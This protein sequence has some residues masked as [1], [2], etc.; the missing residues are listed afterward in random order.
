[1]NFTFVCPCCE[2]DDCREFWECRERQLNTKSNCLKYF[3]EIQRNTYVCMY[4]YVHMCLHY[5]QNF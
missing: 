3:F 2:L 4:L 5:V 1:M